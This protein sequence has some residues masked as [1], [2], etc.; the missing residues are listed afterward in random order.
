MIGAVGP[1]QDGGGSPELEK[2]TTTEW[3]GDRKEGAH[4]G[5]VPTPDCLTQLKPTT[6]MQHI[7][8]HLKPTTHT[9]NTSQAIV[10]VLLSNLQEAVFLLTFITSQISKYTNANK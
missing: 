8:N 1:G 4:R 2:M 10:T 9:C 5:R 3:R 7:P 6:H